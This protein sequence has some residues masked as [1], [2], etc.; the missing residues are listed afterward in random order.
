MT[1]YSEAF[2]ME[3]ERFAIHDGPGIRSTVFMQGCPLRCPWCA[4]PES[5][6]RGKQ[7]LYQAGKCIRCLGCVQV[8]PKG[9]ITVWEG[10]PEFNRDRCVG[11][12]SCRRVCPAGAISYIGSKMTTEAIFQILSRDEAYYR[13]SGGGVTFSGGE[14]F[15][16]FQALYELLLLCHEKGYHTA[17][18]T[19][20]DTPFEN[21]EAA[22][23]LTDLFL[24]DVKHWDR[25]WIG[26]VTGGNGERIQENF[27]RLSLLAA[28]KITARIPVI[29]GY[30][31]SEEDLRKMFAWISSCGVK[32]ADLLPYHTLGVD[33]Y[34][35]LGRKY[36]LASAKMLSKKELAGYKSVGQE[37]G[38]LV[39]I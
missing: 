35:Q 23:P 19:T 28:E 14:P 15:V 6:S 4:N 16:Q 1:Q 39:E 27:R 30:N 25:G 20:G 10:R 37:Y 9:A 18:E 7:L 12:E 11:C 24:F 3:V 33:K 26:R 13:E 8:C 29:P 32:R 2:I 34:S 17:I 22:L 31:D 38:L 5:Q 21:M 36:S